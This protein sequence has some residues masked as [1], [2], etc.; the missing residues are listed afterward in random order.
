M[1]HRR[2]SLALVVL[3]LL[4]PL[5][6]GCAM[7][8]SPNPNQLP[9]SRHDVDPDD[10]AN[11]TNP[12]DQKPLLD[13]EN[14]SEANLRRNFKKL[15]G[16]GP[17][18]SIAR[19]LYSQGSDAYNEA[20]ELEDAAQTQKY[21]EAA[22]HFV[23]A[24]DRWPDTSLEQDALYM[25]GDCY[26]FADRYV[27]AN[28]QYE[29]LVKKYPNSRYLDVVEARRFLI[30]KYWLVANEKEPYYTWFNFT[31]EERP[32]VDTRGN[33]LRLYD[34]IKLDD[35]TGKL[36][37]D[38]TIAAAT[39]RFV[40]GEFEKADEYYTDLITAYPD[41]EH[42][43]N[44][45]YFGLKAKLN[46]YRGS[47]YEGSS[48][49]EGEKLVK[50]MRRQ[51]PVQSRQDRDFL[52]KAFAEI[53]YKKAER[54]WEAGNFYDRR[55]E[56]GGA[57]VYYEV[58]VREY[59]DTPFAERAKRRLEETASEPEVPPQPLQSLV[60]LFPQSDP[61][62]PILDKAMVAPQDAADEDDAEMNISV[63]E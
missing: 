56:Y 49:D 43:Y 6:L 11:G 48:L 28:R 63:S 32:W 26:F 50:Q 45:H 9:K 4:C 18:R 24:A 5:A 62:K 61:L 19:N 41:S 8:Q 14:L 10:V 25:A 59:D 55:R 16:K 37:D 60:N 47:H 38:A 7:F 57:R 58:L 33:A 30:A 35:P 39:E 52:D 21:L 20:R 2:R 34:K 44:A 3:G 15:V 36:A 31:D 53:R 40:K 54:E 13:L 12:D 51:F 1:S 46:S 17:D 42:Q 22:Q 23:D 29:L 27:D